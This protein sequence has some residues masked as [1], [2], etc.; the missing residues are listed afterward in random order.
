MNLKVLHRAP[1]NINLDQ[2]QQF[3]LNRQKNLKTQLKNNI[4]NLDL[5]NT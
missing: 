5:S 3:N 2:N 1:T 4:M